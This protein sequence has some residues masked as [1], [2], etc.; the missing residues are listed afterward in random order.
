[1]EDSYKYKNYGGIG[2][3]VADRWH[4]FSNFCDDIEE[5]DGY[6]PQLFDQNKLNLVNSLKQPHI[7]KSERV[8]GPNTCVLM[9]D[10]EMYWWGS[11]IRR[12]QN[13]IPEQL[14][15]PE[16]REKLYQRWLEKV[17]ER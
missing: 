2:M 10:D 17:S 12:I 11:Q 16:I 3:T 7:P 5:L 14:E 15:R 4:N 9:T 1:M 13:S 8:H 6:D